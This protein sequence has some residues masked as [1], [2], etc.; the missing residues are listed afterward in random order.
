M[1]LALVGL[2][3]E[4]CCKAAETLMPSNVDAL[5]QALSFSCGDPVVRDAGCS[6]SCFLSSVG[7]YLEQCFLGTDFDEPVRRL[8][9]MIQTARDQIALGTK[10][11]YKTHAD[12]SAA[13]WVLK[14]HAP[15]LGIARDIIE[16]AAIKQ[17]AH[18]RRQDASNLEYRCSLIDEFNQK[19]HENSH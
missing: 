18:G 1:L 16:A 6:A 4:L 19:F 10:G 14:N 15:I 2:D 12:E 11:H 3:A 7:Q 13:L 17:S 5:E 9:P 8:L